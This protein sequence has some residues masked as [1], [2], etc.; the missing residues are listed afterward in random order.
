VKI[1]RICQSRRRF[2]LYQAT[3]RILPSLTPEAFLLSG[4]KGSN[5]S[6]AADPDAIL[7]AEVVDFN[8][9]QAAASA[10]LG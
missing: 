5:Q 10:V 4:A 3:P 1:W 7:L 2:L 9:W 8:Q 6:A